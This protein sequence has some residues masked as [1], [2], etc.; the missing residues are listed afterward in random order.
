MVVKFS[1]ISSKK[2]MSLVDFAELCLIDDK[3]DKELDEELISIM[4][5]PNGPEIIESSLLDIG[6]K[7]ENKM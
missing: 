2:R 7:K 5:M 6:L 4:E 1:E 3:V